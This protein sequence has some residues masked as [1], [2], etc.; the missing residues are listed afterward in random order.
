MRIVGVPVGGGPLLVDRVV[1]HGDDPVTL[2]WRD[3]FAVR[4]LLSATGVLPNI[5]VTAQVV[6]RRDWPAGLAR[7][8]SP[9][10][11]RPR[12]TFMTAV[13]PAAPILRQRVAAYVIALSDR[14][15][16]ATQ[17]SDRTAVSGLWGLPG[18]GIDVGET[19]ADAAIREVAEETGQ[20]VILQRILDL[21]SDHW[22]GQSPVGLVEDFHALRLIYVAD[23]PSPTD[24]V[25]W[26]VGGTTAGVRWVPLA[27][28]RRL[29]WSMAF[30]AIL[31]D[32]LEQLVEQRAALA[33]SEGGPSECSA[34]R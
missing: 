21:Q 8:W 11:G 29:P 25:V 9:G 19:A 1:G 3:G 32:H 12:R 2:L 18:G 30:R 28:W 4:R 23:V 14:G 27:A 15:L 13:D 10:F 5:V 34:P 16:L 22:I 17:F 31:A 24:P 6:R 20:T 7:H 33:G 26:D